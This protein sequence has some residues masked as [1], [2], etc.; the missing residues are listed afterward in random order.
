MQT[1]AAVGLLHADVVPVAAVVRPG[2]VEGLETE[3]EGVPGG[4][5]DAVLAVE[6]DGVRRGVLR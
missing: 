4:A 6:V 5:H 3:L 2:Q 1:S